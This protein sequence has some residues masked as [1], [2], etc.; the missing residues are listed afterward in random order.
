MAKR[1]TGLIITKT[2]NKVTNTTSAFVLPDYS[3]F[4]VTKHVEYNLSQV[5]FF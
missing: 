3:I 5:S 4:I 2:E 1:Q